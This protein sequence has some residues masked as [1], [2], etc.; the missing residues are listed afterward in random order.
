MALTG[1]PWLTLIIFGPVLGAIAVALV[2]REQ[3]GLLRNV[4][5]I[6]SLL[7][8]LVSIPLFTNFDPGA[9][10]PFQLTFHRVEDIAWIPAIGA[11]YHVGVDG[12]SMFIILL[13]TVLTPL[14]ILSTY[15]AVE[16]RVKEYMISLLVLE[17]GMIG[18]LAALDVFLFY[19]F[20]ELMLIPMYFI[21]GVWG[22]P[23]RRYAAIK[24]FIY[25]MVGSVL[26]LIALL[27][28]YFKGDGTD[29]SV[30]YMWEVAQSLTRGEQVWLFLCFTLAFAIKVPLFPFHTWLPDAHVEAPTAGSVIL[31]GVLL[32]MGTFGIVR[33]AMPMFPQ[34]FFV[35]APWIAVLSVI[36]IIYGA[37]MAWIQKDIKSLV[38]Y[39]SVSHL[40][41]VVLGLMALTPAGVT[42]GVFQ[43]LA[44]GV[45]TGGLFLGVGFL[46]EQRHKR[47]ID[48]YGGIAKQVPAFSAF[49]V[50]IVLASA[51]LPGLAGF[52]G[53][54]MVL[55]GTAQ[56]EVLTFGG[57]GAFFP[58]I[59]ATACTD[60]GFLAAAA[61]KGPE[62][63]AY[64]FTALAG[65]GVIL[66]A[67]YLLH[68]VKKVFFGPMVHEENTKLRDMNLREV[69]YFLP[70]VLLAG[71]MGINPAFITDRLEGSVGFVIGEIEGD[72][73]R[74]YIEE[75]LD[76]ADER[77]AAALDD[78]L[79]PASDGVE[80]TG[81]EADIERATDDGPGFHLPAG[82][83]YRVAQPVA[84]SGADPPAG[85]P[86]GVRRIV[87]AEDSGFAAG[88]E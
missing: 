63:T 47:G 81:G 68:M 52:I 49:F 84:P 7:V 48:D 43:M 78:G 19:V 40:G 44:H 9:A 34:A 73:E 13:T 6:S 10:E 20:W 66:A 80:R 28:V 37:L 70:I 56:S 67:I 12:I 30:L 15:K 14:C 4:A 51:G 87:V 2:P 24:F 22:G 16:H 42:G 36:G 27:Y 72:Y 64:I 61:C 85:R 75:R 32:K 69:A 18:A 59:Q 29:F 77:E 74:F 76:E 79:R 45:A 58:S 1:I 88:G 21:I 25:T 17:T 38:A 62:I 57:H 60:G 41:F 82:R 23:R 11:R 46:Y 39:S 3:K 86:E 35:F 31:A 71:F 55:M 50:I 65:T 53:E 83:I 26:M 8:F 5:F 33:Y 54:F